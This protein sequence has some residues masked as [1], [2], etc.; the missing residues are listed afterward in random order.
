[1]NPWVL[2][3]EFSA[4]YLST[5]LLIF[6][7]W[8]PKVA[9]MPALWIVFLYTVYIMKRNG[10]SVFTSGYVRRPFGRLVL[11]ML[12]VTAII[13]A[14]TWWQY[15]QRLFEFSMQQPWLWLA[16]ILLYPILSV[17]PQEVAFRRFFFYRYGKL[18][19]QGSA[20]LLVNAL[21]FSY[22]HIVFDNV[23][24]VLFT[25]IGGLL[26]AYTYTRSRSLL[27]VSIEHAV[28]GN[29]IYTFGLGTFFYHNGTFS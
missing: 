18:F 13:G 21:L 6:F 1:M 27:L 26:F 5:P 12:I 2:A 29:A 4:L 15:P 9:V 17:I 22:I 3:V 19:G 28:Y 10:C 8:L 23:L 14:F 11:Q 16:V 25:F 7:G 24:A 20:A